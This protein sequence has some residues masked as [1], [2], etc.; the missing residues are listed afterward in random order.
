MKWGKHTKGRNSWL[1]P[2]KVSVAERSPQQISPKFGTCK[3]SMT[4]TFNLQLGR[5]R[6]RSL[7]DREEAVKRAQLQ[8]FR[9]RHLRFK[10]TVV[11]RWTLRYENG[12]HPVP[13]A[14]RTFLWWRANYFRN[15]VIYSL[16]VGLLMMLLTL[17]YALWR[18]S[19]KLA[20]MVLIINA[21]LTI[22]MIQF[23]YSTY[24]DSVRLC[25]RAMIAFSFCY[26]CLL[27][28]YTAVSADFSYGMHLGCMF[29]VL[30]YLPILAHYGE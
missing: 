13:Q 15:L 1:K 27:V 6:R 24:Y 17:S 30:N 9:Q 19:L 23:C 22:F 11:D 18:L 28:L 26:A 21:I 4:D 5:N 2:N 29:W 14:E 12:G 25:S 20:T 10:D 8:W 16:W 7:D 3:I